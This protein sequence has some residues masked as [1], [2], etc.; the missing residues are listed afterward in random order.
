MSLVH[1]H[2]CSPIFLFLHNS[3]VFHGLFSITFFFEIFYP[4]KRLTNIMSYS[5]QASA[6]GCRRSLGRTEGTDG[7]T[8]LGGASGEHQ[9]RAFFESFSITFFLCESD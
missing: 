1:L 2:I 8:E 4:S 7:G 3:N 5:P 6:L 9:R